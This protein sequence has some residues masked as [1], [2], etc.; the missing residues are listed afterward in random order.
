LLA[1]ARAGIT[2]VL[3]PARHRK[4]LEDVLKRHANSSIVWLERVEMRYAA[5]LVADDARGIGVTRDRRRRSRTVSRPYRMTA[6]GVP[7]IAGHARNISY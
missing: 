5:A 7:V 4:D 3:L 1:A 2:T 6:T